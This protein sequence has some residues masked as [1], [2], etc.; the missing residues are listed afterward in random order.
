MRV[1][2][3]ERKA[4][5]MLIDMGLLPADALLSPTH[6]KQSYYTQAL[7]RAFK[8]SSGDLSAGGVSGECSKSPSVRPAAS[9]DARS[10]GLDC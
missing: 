5:H 6:M 9:E 10:H 4:F 1:K 2:D 7:E 3:E 8:F